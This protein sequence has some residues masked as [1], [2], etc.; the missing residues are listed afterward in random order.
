[1]KRQNK[2]F[3]LVE[4]LIVVVIIGILAA[5]LI[6]RLIGAQATAR[7]TSRST[8]LNQVMAWLEQYYGDAWK[9][10]VAKWWPD[11]TN[12]CVAD[13]SWDLVWGKYMSDIPKDPQAVGTIVN[14]CGSK[15][16]WAYSLLSN[17]SLA[18]GWYWI[19]AKVEWEKAANV[20]SFTADPTASTLVAS[21]AFLDPSL[22]WARAKI[23]NVAKGTAW[24]RL[25]RA[26]LANN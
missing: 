5:A 23:W 15:N 24:P 19:V 4:M 13:L 14:S 20:T 3:T 7:D 25:Y 17:N 11:T 22:S 21:T 10:P 26:Q 6:P 1:M 12:G 9:Y 18:D 16:T 8:G 2:A